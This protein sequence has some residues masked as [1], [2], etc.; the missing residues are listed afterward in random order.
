[1][2][3]ALT[4]VVLGSIVAASFIAFGIATVWFYGLGAFV[5]IPALLAYGVGRA[6]K[7]P[8]HDRLWVRIVVTQAALA[9]TAVVLFATGFEGAICLVMTW[10]IAAPAAVV[11]AVAAHRRREAPTPKLKDYLTAGAAVPLFL[12]AEPLIPYPAPV[13]PVRTEV[14]VDAPIETV[15]EHVVSF[16]PLPA[17]TEFLFR[18]GV[19]YPM[20]AEIDGEGVGAVRRCVFSTGEFVE[21]VTAWERPTLLAFDVAESPIPMK[22]WSPYEEIHPAHLEGYF[23]SVRGQFEL[24]ELPDGGTRLTG[25][26]WRVVE[27]YPAAY[28]ELWADWIVHRIHLRV[29]RHIR[30]LAEGG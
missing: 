18:T 30:D 24:E 26:T 1:M 6:Y 29:L 27:I 7:G 17:P 23:R 16:E 2:K 21:P 20:R 9:L 28:W 19:A 11:G 22:E 3:N 14:V 13:E 4:V 5:L 10:P 12:V 25:T 15:W 8:G